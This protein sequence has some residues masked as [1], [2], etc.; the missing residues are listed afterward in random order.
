MNTVYYNHNDMVYTLI[1]HSFWSNRSSDPLSRQISKVHMYFLILIYS[2]EGR[3]NP[4]NTYVMK[5]H[6]PVC[7]CNYKYRI[8]LDSY[9][10]VLGD[11]EYFFSLTSRVIILRPLHLRTSEQSVIKQMNIQVPIF[12]LTIEIYIWINISPIS[13]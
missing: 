9:S 6:F 10:L 4:I 7:I 1:D 13:P 3:E 2:L 12:K 8:V 11:F 5:I